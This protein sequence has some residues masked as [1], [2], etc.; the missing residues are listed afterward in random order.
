VSKNAR[1]EKFEFLKE[2]RTSLLYGE[3]VRPDTAPMMDQHK[4][5]IPKY[6]FGGKIP[7]S[8]TLTLEWDDE[9]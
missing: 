6:V 2:K 1:S 9:F 8:I 4:I 5:Y 7:S 3:A